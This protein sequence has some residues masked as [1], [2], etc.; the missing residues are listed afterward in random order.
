[1]PLLVDCGMNIILTSGVDV[2]VVAL[3]H[4]SRVYLG[5]TSLLDLQSLLS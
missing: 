3:G 4:R 1:L 2:M 5:N